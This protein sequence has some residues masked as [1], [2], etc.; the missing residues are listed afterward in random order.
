M[1]REGK[2][3]KGRK[4]NGT[5]RPDSY[6]GVKR[7]GGKD[8]KEKEGRKKEWKG[9]RERERERERKGRQIMTW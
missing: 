7:E 5:E 9:R 2:K 3:G 1:D 4:E 8:E 6:T